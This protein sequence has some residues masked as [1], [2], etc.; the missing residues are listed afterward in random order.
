MNKPKY[1]SVPDSYMKEL[2]RAIDN[3]DMRAL[4]SNDF[5]LFE[6]IMSLKANY[7]VCGE[8]K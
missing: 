4:R 7:V 2:I 8:K 3:A 1:H 5:D 6:A